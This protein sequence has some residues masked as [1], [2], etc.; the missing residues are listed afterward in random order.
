M[1]RRP[2]VPREKGYPRRPIGPEHELIGTIPALTLVV[3][4]TDAAGEIVYEDDGGIQVAAQRHSGAPGP[5]LDVQG[6]LI[7]VP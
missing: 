5:G 3:R 6:S 7:M 1:G 4:I 2:C